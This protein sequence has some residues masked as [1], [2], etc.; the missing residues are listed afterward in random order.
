MAKRTRLDRLRRCFDP[1]RFRVSI[2]LDF[3]SETL[4]L[5][6]HMLSGFESCRLDTD[7][8]SGAQKDAEL[9]DVA[10]SRGIERAM[11]TAHNFSAPP[12]DFDLVGIN[13]LVYAKMREV[14]KLDPDEEEAP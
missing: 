6:L 7:T 1:N 9:G 5:S 3:P 2:V 10:T 12:S 14:V 11:N 13:C 8:T 4:N